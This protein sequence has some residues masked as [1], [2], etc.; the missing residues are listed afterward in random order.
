MD[1]SVSPGFPQRG[2]RMTWRLAGLDRREISAS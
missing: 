1:F 2:V